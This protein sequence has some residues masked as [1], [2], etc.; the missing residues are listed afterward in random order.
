LPGMDS[1]EEINM[2]T[3]PEV[4]D[5]MP[6]PPLFD[7]AIASPVPQV[8]DCACGNTFMDD[9]IF[10]RK[11]GNERPRKHPEDEGTAIAD[12]VELE[13][14]PIAVVPSQPV[15]AAP[16][17]Y[18]ADPSK[19]PRYDRRYDHHSS[20]LSVIESSTQPAQQASLSTSSMENSPITVKSSAS[21]PKSSL[22]SASKVIADSPNFISM[23]SSARK[24]VPGQEAD[25]GLVEKP[26][27]KRP[28]AAI[29]LS[30][31]PLQCRLPWDAG[32][33][34]TR[35]PS[36]AGKEGMKKK[37]VEVDESSQGSRQR[38]SSATPPMQDKT[39]IEVLSIAPAVFFDKSNIELSKDS[40]APPNLPWLTQPSAGKWLS[41]SPLH[42]ITTV[43]GSWLL[44]EPAGRWMAPLA[45]D[46][47]SQ[48]DVRAE[49]ALQPVRQ[50]VALKDTTLCELPPPSQL[51]SNKT[52]AKKAEALKLEGDCRGAALSNDALRSENSALR[53]EL[54]RLLVLA[55]PSDTPPMSVR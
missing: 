16:L 26:W 5:M 10:C 50:A 29:F 9:S 1:E 35:P 32:N 6:T 14:P 13:T 21:A 49:A 24:V 46:V 17:P 27:A 39:Q 54:E 51:P 19:V 31:A 52:S 37:V 43:D 41:H 11:C 30:T 53:E 20:T 47:R 55:S 44:R 28:I 12:A 36:R 42:A 4:L 18:Q 34:A 7:S 40:T 25:S 15:V 3:T 22:S 2:P 38:D 33:W 23:P 48:K 8:A 45:L